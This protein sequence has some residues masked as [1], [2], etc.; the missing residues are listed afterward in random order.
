MEIK[1]I[2]SKVKVYGFDESIEASKYPM[3]VELDELTSDVT[4]TVEKLASSPKGEGHDNFLNGIVVQFNL[5][6]TVKE[7]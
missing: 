4:P 6:F 3:A 2:I 1:D 7:G 5:K